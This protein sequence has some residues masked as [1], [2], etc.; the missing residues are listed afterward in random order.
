MK[1]IFVLLFLCNLS[2]KS[3][4]IDHSYIDVDP[5]S[6]T[7]NDPS[8]RTDTDKD[9]TDKD[10]VSDIKDDC[11]G[12]PIGAVVNKKGCPLDTDKD[13]IPDYL[14]KQP[15]SIKGE[16]V[17]L[18]GTTIIFKDKTSIPDEYQSVDTNNDDKISVDEISA[19]I[20]L[21]FDDKS[22]LT[23]P[24]LSELINYFFDQN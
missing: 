1:Y 23:L 16:P 4:T 17:D 9:D 3:Q 24:Q 13:G 8:F 7:L 22:P 12:T 20:D 2:V 15:N 18:T 19:S 6:K 5:T 14:D 21:F 10:G 11:Q